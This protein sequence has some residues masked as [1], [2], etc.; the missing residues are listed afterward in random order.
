MKVY[1][2]KNDILRFIA[3]IRA[4][5]ATRI[6]CYMFFT[7]LKSIE[8]SAVAYCNSEHIITKIGNYYYDF[9]G[10]VSKQ[11]VEDSNYL[12]LIK[13]YGENHVV[14]YLYSR[15]GYNEREV[16]EAVERSA[17]N[18]KERYELLNGDTPHQDIQLPFKKGIVKPLHAR[19][20][21]GT[22]TGSL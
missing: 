14:N 22:Q 16:K 7:I 10:E 18:Y 3:A 17:Y 6:Q 5:V 11:E 9:D 12:D 19:P 1:L 4:S 8:S 15:D 13:Y 2:K 20:I 21:R